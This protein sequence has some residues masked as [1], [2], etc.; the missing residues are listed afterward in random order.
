MRNFLKAGIILF[1]AFMTVMPAFAQ[2]GE[3]DFVYRRS[4]LYPI[5]L[6]T[7]PVFDTPE[8]KDLNDI[9]MRFYGEAPFPDKYND[10]RLEM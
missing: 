2:D 3:G 1:L 9:V 5:L 4:S 8:D 7:D 10:H 6:E